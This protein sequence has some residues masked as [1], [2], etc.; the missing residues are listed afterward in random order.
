MV[1]IK[2][3]TPQLQKCASAPGQH[4]QSVPFYVPCHSRQHCHQIRLK[5]KITSFCNNRVIKIENNTTYDN[6]SN[7]LQ[8]QRI[9]VR[10]LLVSYSEPKSLPVSFVSRVFHASWIGCC[11]LSLFLPLYHLSCCHRKD[12]ITGYCI[13]ALS[14][15]CSSPAS[16][17]QFLLTDTLHLDYTG[18]HCLFFLSSVCPFYALKWFS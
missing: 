18:V 15:V 14:S 6:S 7:Y 12:R 3:Y 1:F 2:I 13:Y 5:E 16:L 11:W 8:E 10:S 4:K 17:F 9:T